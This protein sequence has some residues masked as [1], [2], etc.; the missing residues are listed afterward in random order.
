MM[1]PDFDPEEL[2]GTAGQAVDVLRRLMLSN[3]ESSEMRLQAAKAILEFTGQVM[4][5]VTESAR[6][7]ED[8]DLDF[9]D[10]EEEEEE[11]E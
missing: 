8:D 7:Y 6:A 4:R 2:M 1:R 3:K 11:E 10:E 9:E 5:L